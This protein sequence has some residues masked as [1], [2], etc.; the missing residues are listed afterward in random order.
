MSLGSVYV[1]N[2]DTIFKIMIHFWAANC[3]GL[4]YIKVK[5]WNK[6]K[7]ISNC[8]IEKKS[9]TEKENNISW[10]K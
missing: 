7:I 4:Y 6:F 8:P 9:M 10:L 2:D 1:S 5:N 3:H